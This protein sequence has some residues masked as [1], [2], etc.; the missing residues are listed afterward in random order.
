VQLG[1]NFDKK[2]S[3]LQNEPSIM[4]ALFKQCQI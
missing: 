4:V 1:P 2:Q 3:L